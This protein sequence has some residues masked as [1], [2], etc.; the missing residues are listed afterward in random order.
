MMSPCHNAT[1]TLYIY[2]CVCVCVQSYVYV[3][4][5][6][7]LLSTSF[8]ASRMRTMRH[9]MMRH[10]MMDGQPMMCH[11]M[12]GQQPMMRHLMMHTN[13]RYAVR[14]MKYNPFSYFGVIIHRLCCRRLMVNCVPLIVLI[15]CY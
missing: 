12:M 1:F 15:K 3:T 2:I 4:S 7:F 8:R 6:I 13:K 11:L 14:I 10:L 5:S 9:P